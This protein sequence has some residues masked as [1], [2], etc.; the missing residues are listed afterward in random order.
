MKKF[1][2]LLQ[3][4]VI[5]GALVATILLLVLYLSCTN[6]RIYLSNHQ[7]DPNFI[8]GFFTV[9]ALLLSLIQTSKDKRYA[10][11]LQLVKSI[12]DKGLLVIAKLISIK[13][14]SLVYV[15]TIK[16]L[17]SVFG[18][19]RI[20]RDTNEVLSKTEIEKGMEL[21]ATYLDTFFPAIKEKWND[22]T[23]RLS[24]LGTISTNIIINYNENY[25]LIGTKGFTNIALDN[26]DASIKR[27]DVLN[28]EIDQ[29]TLEMRDSI[30]GKINESTG[31]FKNTFDFSF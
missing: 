16:Q 8:I 4:H 6:F 18:T 12:E 5:L 10:Y 30:V 3:N 20:Y 21:V 31:E 11:N 29:I 17:K 15:G 13:G 27:A 2:K 24:E 1:V 22:L 19:N 23:D 25:N 14:R 9:I 26:I 28:Q 7:I